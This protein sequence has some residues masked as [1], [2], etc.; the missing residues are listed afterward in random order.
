[1]EKEKKGLF[2]RLLDFWREKFE[3]GATDGIGFWNDAETVENHLAEMGAVDF[4]TQEETKKAFWEETAET[5]MEA[6]QEEAGILVE[7]KNIFLFQKEAEQEENGEK[8][9]EEVSSEDAEKR[10]VSRLFTA[11]V[12]RNGGRETEETEENRLRQAFMWEMPEE[13]RTVRNII[14][15]AEEVEREEEPETEATEEIRLETMPEQKEKQN[16]PQIDIEKLMRQMTKK[17]WEERESC[18]RRLR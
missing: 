3:T 9:P 13:K 17:L 18:G 7:E 12:F 2:G 8:E 11:D 4:L 14:P 10:G 6:K 5:V 1:M 15:V 16:E